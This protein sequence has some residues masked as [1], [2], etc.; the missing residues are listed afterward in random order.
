MK[1]KYPRAAV[2]R[3][4]ESDTQGRKRVE[5]HGKPMRYGTATKLAAMEPL[6]YRAR[7]KKMTIRKAAE[8]MGW[9]ESALRNWIKVLGITWNSRSR[10]RRVYKYD[11][12]GWSERIVDGL[13]KGEPMVSIAKALGVGHWMVVRHTREN[14]LWAV[15]LNKLP[16]NR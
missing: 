2:I 9:S 1:P 8:W 10:K 3:P 15:V 5:F 16:L 11:R 14:G 7:A 13:T 4:I 12:T 6:I